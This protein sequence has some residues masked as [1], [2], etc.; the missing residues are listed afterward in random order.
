MLTVAHSLRI[1][2]NITVSQAVSLA[3]ASVTILSKA[4]CFSQLK[5][6]LALWASQA[7]QASQVAESA[8]SPVAPALLCSLS[9][10]LFPIF[11]ID[12]DSGWNILGFLLFVQIFFRWLLSLI[13]VRFGFFEKFLPLSDT[14]IK[15]VIPSKENDEQ[16][17]S[18]LRT[19]IY[20]KIRL[21][22]NM[23]QDELRNKYRNNPQ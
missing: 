20:C 3:A 12:G 18:N 10:S 4:A 21:V 9:L 8:P 5:S 23:V 15:F 7:S 6:L 11:E 22:A 17:K 16:I 2:V 14:M 19:Y 13:T 1:A